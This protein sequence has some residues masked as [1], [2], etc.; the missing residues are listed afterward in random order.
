MDEFQL[1]LILS[2]LTGIMFS[3]IIVLL[4]FSLPIHD[5]E[6]IKVLPKGNL[7]KISQGLKNR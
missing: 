4:A 2:V 1:K 6:E 3:L 5:K 7:E